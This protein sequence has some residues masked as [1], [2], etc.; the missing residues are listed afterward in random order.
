MKTKL[1]RIRKTLGQ[2]LV[3]TNNIE[4]SLVVENEIKG[5]INRSY[6]PF[7]ACMHKDPDM[8]ARM[9]YDPEHSILDH[10]SRSEQFCLYFEHKLVGTIRFSVPKLTL[11]PSTKIEEMTSYIGLLAIDPKYSKNG[12][13]NLMINFC[14]ELFSQLNKSEKSE[15]LK[16]VR[17]TL[18]TLTPVTSDFLPFRFLEKWYAKHGFGL[19]HVRDA[20]EDANEGKLFREK[21]KYE[22]LE[23]KEFEYRL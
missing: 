10:L 14:K 15:E 12:Y 1:P 6:H 18:L 16:V 22:K 4:T 17:L 11:N 13:S 19:I 20:M 21:I 3:I 7:Y 8:Y 9:D 23:F 5:L 2:N